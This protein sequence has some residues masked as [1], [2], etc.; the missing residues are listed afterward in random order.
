MA[1]NKNFAR[2]A[3]TMDIFKGLFTATKHV[4]RSLDVFFCP[5]HGCSFYVPTASTTFHFF[6]CEKE[7]TAAL[8]VGWSRGWCIVYSYC[9]GSI[10]II[11][12]YF[13]R[14]LT[15]F[16]ARMCPQLTSA[17]GGRGG[18]VAASSSPS[19]LLLL[20]L[21]P[22]LLEVVEAFTLSCPC[23]SKRFEYSSSKWIVI[24]N[25]DY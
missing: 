10:C 23:C 25:L 11:I 21:F 6:H 14:K 7:N 18:G 2:H 24:P 17:F 5:R 15:W 22:P 19:P 8:T 20:L 13:F 16:C 12:F 4:G 9:T 3:P 1:L